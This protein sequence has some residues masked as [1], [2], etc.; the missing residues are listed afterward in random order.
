[1]GGPQSRC[2][3][4]VLSLTGFETW[5]FQSVVYSILRYAEYATPTPTCCP[6]Y[7]TLQP[8]LEYIPR[9]PNQRYEFFSARPH[10]LTPKTTCTGQ[11]SEFLL[12]SRCN[13]SQLQLFQ[14]P[15]SAPPCIFLVSL[16]NLHIYLAK[17]FV[18]LV[19]TSLHR[20][21]SFMRI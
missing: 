18:Q 7:G 5:T 12:R 21:N 6:L 2:G 20:A 3:L 8:K 13:S 1:M 4:L 11:K 10:L 15:C 14:R 19:N 9:L 16:K 17:Y